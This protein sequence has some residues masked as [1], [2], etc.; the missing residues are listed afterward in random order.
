[1]QLSCARNHCT[2]LLFACGQRSA[3]SDQRPAT[4][5]L[6]TRGVADSHP[7]PFARVI[8]LTSVTAIRPV[9]EPATRWVC[10][11]GGGG[12]GARLAVE[13]VVGRC[14]CGGLR[15]PRRGSA[16]SAMGDLQ[17]AVLVRAA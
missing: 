13:R 1:M 9:L 16:L 17:T 14:G 11:W 7:S 15:A 2:V 12:G 10:V 6:Q 5:V 3:V 8:V 4:S